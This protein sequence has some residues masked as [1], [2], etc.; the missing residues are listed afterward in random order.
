MLDRYGRFIEDN[1]DYII[2]Q[3]LEI[4]QKENCPRY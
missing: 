4:G 3:A 2:S 1:R